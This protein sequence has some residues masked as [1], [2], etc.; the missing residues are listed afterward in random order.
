MIEV[1]KRLRPTW[2][3][4]LRDGKV[5]LAIVER[6]YPRTDQVHRLV[7]LQEISFPLVERGNESVHIFLDAD[8]WIL[9]QI[10]R[11]ID[12]RDGTQPARKMGAS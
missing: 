7:S 10:N 11:A 1:L 6:P 3:L 9:Y 5:V 2:G 4:S 12:E 8:E